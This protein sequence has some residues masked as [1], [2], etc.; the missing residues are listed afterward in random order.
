METQKFNIMPET[1][2]PPKQKT[3]PPTP[4]PIPPVAK[5]THIVKAIESKVES[6]S[7]ESSSSESSSSSENDSESGSESESES[8]SS[9]EESEAKAKEFTHN[10]KIPTSLQRSKKKVVSNMMHIPAS[11]YHFNPEDD[12]DPEYEI[13]NQGGEKFKVFSY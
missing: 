12:Y 4:S 5:V 6:I 11:H 7:S 10:I 9:S 3:I 8:E 13:L 1:F 2:I